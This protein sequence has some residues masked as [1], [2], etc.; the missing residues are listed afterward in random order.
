VP[1]VIADGDIPTTRLL[2]RELRA[3][4][5]EVE[6]RI[7]DTLFG[8][9]VRERTVIVS[10]LCHPRMRWLADYLVE[11]VGYVYFLDDNFWE[12]TPETDP[13]LANFFNH[14]AAVATLDTF[15]QRARRVVTWSTRLR[16][17]VKARFPAQ[18][19]VTVAPGFDVAAVPAPLAA[20]G[21]PGAAPFRVGY[22]TTRKLALTPLLCE[23]VQG[24]ARA[25]GDEVRFEFMGWMPEALGASPN[26][27]LL[28]EVEDYGRYLA[29]IA[30]RGWNAAIAPLLPGRFES[31]KTDIK[32]REYGG[33]GIAGVYS[34]VPPYDEAVVDGVTGLLVGNEAQH[35]IAAIAR[36]RENPSLGLSLARNARED[37]VTRHDLRVTGRALATAIAS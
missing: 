14:P 22:P 26:A 1:L 28:P 12:L 20:A 24:A 2:A 6:V 9:Q 16:D 32:Y 11:R 34:S 21:A 37:I 7:P 31:Y 23:I 35:W 33:C 18:D 8:A 19:V 17:Y 27:S 13:H 29:T 3:A 25:F 30:G 36:L 4:Y 10:R 15:A 5:P